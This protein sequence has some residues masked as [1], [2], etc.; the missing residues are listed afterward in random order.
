MDKRAASE[1]LSF[2]LVF[3]M[4][5]SAV[6]LI[7]VSGLGTLQDTRDAEQLNNAKRAFDVLSDNMADLH[8]RG[9]PS[10]ATEISLENAQL[11]TDRNVTINVSVE[12][13]S[14]GW[15]STTREVRPLVYE[16]NQ[17]RKLVYEGGA[18][19][20]TTREGG[21]IDKQPP[22]VARDGRVLLPIVQTR[23][24]NVRSVGGTTVLV[25]ASSESTSVPITNGTSDTVTNV[26]VN[27]T[28][29]RSDIWREYLETTSVDACRQG[30]DADG[31]SF[32][33]CFSGSGPSRVYVPVHA[34]DVDIEL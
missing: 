13:P 17:D 23:T 9:A 1:V 6:A 20:H 34:T 7:S 32:V 11:Y 2:A 18:V 24:G 4:V 25:R 10:R 5:V 21:R 22:I 19:F 14:S 28:S 31:D 15:I 16:A 27:V 33:T 26:S 29:P 3:G 30:T 12:S 8:Q